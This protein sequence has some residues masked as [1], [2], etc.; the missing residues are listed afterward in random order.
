M[1]YVAPLA[2]ASAIGCG[3]AGVSSEATGET[4]QA[5]TAAGVTASVVVTHNAQTFLATVTV[6]NS[7]A[8]P[9]SN[10]QVAMNVNGATVQQGTNGAEAL[11]VGAPVA[12]PAPP[13]PPPGVV[14]FA[15]TSNSPV[16]AP[17]AT[18]SFTFS[19]AFKG[20]FVAPTIVSVDGVANGTAGAGMPADGIDHIARAAATG[21]LNLAIAYENNKLPTNGDVNYALYDNLIWAAQ[22]YVV[23]AGKIQFDPNMPGY[24]FIPNQAL[25][26]LD[27]MQDNAEVASY[28]SAGLTSCFADT[29]A[30]WIYN[31]R[32]AVLKGALSD[33]TTTGTV[34]GQLPPPND[35]VPAGYNPNT[36]VDNFTTVGLATGGSKINVTLTST[37]AHADFWF[38]LLTY[39]SLATFG[40]PAA[41]VAKFNASGQTVA[42][43]PF[44]GPGGTANPYF[45]MTLNGQNVPARFT[46]VGA[47]CY[48][49]CTSTMVLDP[50]AYA[51]PGAYYNTTGLVGPQPNPFG[52]DPTQTAAT[53]DH[54]GQWA[55]T[56]SQYGQTV[57][58]SFS[59]PIVHR[60]VTTGYGWQQ[61]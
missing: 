33:K 4:D 28:L 22:S 24:A 42:C 56:T 49:V 8:E 3:G 60:G 23:S 35:Y 30:G 61:D 36:A 50:I 7:G 2:I 45:A 34:P 48:S 43:S 57:Y 21:A 41:I 54:A 47:Q 14:V 16:L 5:S 37:V 31:F 17:G 32:T 12:P 19:A 51:T 39:T 15:P 29:K 44:N 38:G 52:F 18:A 46:G 40:S 55:T 6:T 20:A 25:A 13:P 58:G 1:L 59:S 27:A 9:A 26:A 53:I 11:N 10:W